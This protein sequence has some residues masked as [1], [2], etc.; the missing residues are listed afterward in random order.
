MIK[1]KTYAKINLTLEVLNKRSNDGL[2]KPF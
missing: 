1:V 2:W